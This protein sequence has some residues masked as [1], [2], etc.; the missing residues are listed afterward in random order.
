MEYLIEIIA[1]INSLK[2]ID[3]H[4][5]KIFYQDRTFNKSLVLVA[6]R[7]QYRVEVFLKDIKMNVYLGKTKYYAIRVEI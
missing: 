5:K 1:K 3:E 2:L 7:F 4:I 6:R